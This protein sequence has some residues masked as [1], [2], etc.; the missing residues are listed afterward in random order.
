MVSYCEERSPIEAMIGCVDCVPE[1]V[2]WISSGLVE[3]G[4]AGRNG[5][6]RGC[7]CATSK[8]QG[9]AADSWKAAS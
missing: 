7:E 6:G 3:A 8:E 9:S 1:M 4:K 2:A 5:H